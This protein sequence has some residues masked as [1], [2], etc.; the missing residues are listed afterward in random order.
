MN[1]TVLLWTGKPHKIES[2]F[3]REVVAV[4]VRRPSV[5]DELLVFKV[6]FGD[7]GKTFGHRE[8]AFSLVFDGG[9]GIAFHIKK[10]GQ[11]HSQYNESIDN[12]NP[13]LFHH[14]TPKYYNMELR[15]FQENPYFSANSAA[16]S[17]FEK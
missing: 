2:L 11:G 10:S 9:L 8:K 15:R 13:P 3:H 12:K 7:A 4:D 14:K 17:G 6:I 1:R 16:G 5:A